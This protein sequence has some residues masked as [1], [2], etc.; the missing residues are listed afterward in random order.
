MDHKPEYLLTDDRRTLYPLVYPD[1]NEFYE[2]Q[3]KA[4]W[5]DVEIDISSDKMDW[6]LLDENTK[7]LIKK[8]LAFFATADSIVGENLITKFISECKVPE[9]RSFYAIQ[10]YIEDIHHR[11]Y[12]KMII[13]LIDDEKERMALFNAIELDPAIKSKAEWATKWITEDC[14]YA[15]RLLGMAIVEEIFFS[16]SFSVPWN[17]AERNVMPGFRSSNKLI[18]IDEGLHVEFALHL[19]N[20]HIQNK[21][22]QQIIVDMTTDAVEIELNF[23]RSAMSSNIPN[24]SLEDELNYVRYVADRFLEKLS[25]DP[26]YGVSTNPLP[27]MDRQALTTITNFFDV[28]PTEYQVKAGPDEDEFAFNLDI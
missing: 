9:V 23:V 17:L 3:A 14:P 4:K 11:T 15:Q 2:R 22:S 5:E 25:I 26:I 20:N 8:I 1:I 18:A 19:Y 21:L 7:T 28:R 16:S 24:L 12:S 10:A 13:A 6:M 27:F